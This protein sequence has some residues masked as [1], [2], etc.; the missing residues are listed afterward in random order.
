MTF[1]DVEVVDEHSRVTHPSCIAFRNRF[2]QPR[3][4]RSIRDIFLAHIP[5]ASMVHRNLPI[6]A[7]PPGIKVPHGDVFRHAMMAHY[8]EIHQVGEPNQVMA[9]YRVHS[10]GVWGGN[11]AIHRNLNHMRSLHGIA[12]AID[13]QFIN[14]ACYQLGRSAFRCGLYALKRRDQQA[15]QQCW[16]CFLA[17]WCLAFRAQDK[18]YGKGI[19]D[20]IVTWLRLLFVPVAFLLRILFRPLGIKPHC[21]R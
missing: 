3:Q 2:P 9:R 14:E 18:T 15:F 19:N 5:S 13:P 1:H 16:R 20:L 21:L 7:N 8:G 12:A 10:G 17:A 4:L 11:H 6:P